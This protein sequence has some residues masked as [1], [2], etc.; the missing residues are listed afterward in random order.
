MK[1]AT[2]KWWAIGYFG[3]VGCR[4]EGVEPW[5]NEGQEEEVR[6]VIAGIEKSLK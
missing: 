6:A 3:E 2:K 5:R 4:E 1:N